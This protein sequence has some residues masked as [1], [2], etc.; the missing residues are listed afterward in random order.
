MIMRM[1]CRRIRGL[2]PLLA[3]GELEGSLLQDAR[4][5]VATCAACRAELMAFG[6]Q[7]LLL[8]AMPAPSS[9]DSVWDAVR[10]RIDEQQK[11]SAQP[12]LA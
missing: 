4:Q 11:R 7:S 9:P 1:E 5:H 6:H 3:G 2:L 10:D 12:P 8:K